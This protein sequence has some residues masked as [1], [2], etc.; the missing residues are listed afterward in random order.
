MV[1][2][3]D[4]DG[5]S[6]RRA[7]ASGGQGAALH[8]LKA[9]GLKNPIAELRSG[10]GGGRLARDAFR[11]AGWRFREGKTDRTARFFTEKTRRFSCPKSRVFYLCLEIPR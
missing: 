1:W 4:G 3:E 11:R 6:P 7:G 10:C 8:P 2:V 9:E 5:E